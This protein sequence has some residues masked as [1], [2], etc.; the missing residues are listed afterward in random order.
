MAKVSTFCTLLESSNDSKRL[1]NY[2]WQKT[3]LS[4]QTFPSDV[5]EIKGNSQK[6]LSSEDE[7]IGRCSALVQEC[8]TDWNSCYNMLD[9]IVKLRTPIQL[10]LSNSDLIPSTSEWHLMEEVVAVLKPLKLITELYSGDS[11]P[12][13]SFVYPTLIGLINKHLQTEN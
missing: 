1:P 6:I 5:S 2:C 11:Y 3:C 13:M 4:L 7:S 12:M 8:P 10:V 9:R